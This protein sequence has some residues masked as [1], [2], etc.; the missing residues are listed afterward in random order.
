MS[1]CSDM[2]PTTPANLHPQESPRGLPSPALGSC[3]LLE[4][5]L[6][7]PAGIGKHQKPAPRMAFQIVGHVISRKYHPRCRSETPAKYKSR[8]QTAS[9]R[10]EPFDT[11]NACN[12]EAGVTERRGIIFEDGANAIANSDNRQEPRGLESKESASLY[13]GEAL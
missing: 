3:S 10:P 2:F 1:E 7:R 9:A 5:R 11:A 13:R 12:G 6:Q 4:C 8:A